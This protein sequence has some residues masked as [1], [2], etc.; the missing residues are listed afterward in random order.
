MGFMQTTGFLGNHTT[1]MLDVVILSLGLITPALLLG[2]WMAKKKKYSIHARLMLSLSIILLVAVLL[3]EID[4]RLNGGIFQIAKRAGRTAQVDT[5]FFLGLLYT[6]IFFSITTLFLWVI[7]IWQA[8]KSFSLS[9][10][11]PTP[12]NTSHKRLGMLSSIDMFL[13]AVTG[14]MCYWIAFIG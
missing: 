5:P 3:F 13:V 6:H 8:I 12:Q 7:T 9:H 2:L 11:T 1:L 4:I 14:A 10:P